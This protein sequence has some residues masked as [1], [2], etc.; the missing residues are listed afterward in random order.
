MRKLGMVGLIGLG[1]WLGAPVAAQAGPKPTLKRVKYMLN[2]VYWRVQWSGMCL[3]E[4]FYNDETKAIP[5]V[6]VVAL[7]KSD[8]AF[9]T[10]W[11]L[12]LRAIRWLKRQKQANAW[13]ALY[14]VARV[15][16]HAKV[17][18]YLASVL[19]HAPALKQD[20][21]ATLKV[22]S[23]DKDKAVRGEAKRSIAQ[24]QS[25][26]QA[27]RGQAHSARHQAG[28]TSLSVPPSDTGDVGHSSRV[29]MP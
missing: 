5:W 14:K 25:R 17:R 24:L 6:A 23:K 15:E 4:D 29:A 13:S 26:L 21:L 1:L 27:N 9:T 16:K 22:L 8:D 19:G 11:K 2:H 7:K 28:A 3:L 12:R 18:L 20:A 10:N